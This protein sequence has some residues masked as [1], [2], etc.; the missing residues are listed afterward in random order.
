MVEIRPRLVVLDS[1]SR[2]CVVKEAAPKPSKRW[3]E[4]QE[5]SVSHEHVDGPWWLLLPFEG[6]AVLEPSGALRVV[7]EATLED[8]MELV[9]YSS[10]EGTKQL[11]AL[12]PELRELISNPDSGS[13]R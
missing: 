7:R 8:A 5:R 11:V 4:E 6:G 9:K 13:R 3:L 10:V 12:F 1:W 2:T